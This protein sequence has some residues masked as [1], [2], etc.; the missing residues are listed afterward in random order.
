MEPCIGYFINGG[1]PVLNGVPEFDI[2]NRTINQAG[3][4]KCLQTMPAGN[5]ATATFTHTT[6]TAGWGAAVFSNP[7]AAVALGIL[8][9]CLFA[10]Y[11]YL[12]RPQTNILI[13]DRDPEIHVVELPI[14]NEPDHK[15]NRRPRNNEYFG[16]IRATADSFNLSPRKARL[17]S[18]YGAYN[19]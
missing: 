13:I 7:G 12:N 1:K 14:N 15:R 5:Y 16:T 18:P 17:A 9:I 6:T 3:G 19:N 2:I 10:A 4:F 8:A 11:T